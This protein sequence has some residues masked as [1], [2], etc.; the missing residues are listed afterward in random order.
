M[1][2]S[3]L[4]QPAPPQTSVGRPFGRPPWVISSKPP[5]PVG[6]LGRGW[7]APTPGAAAEMWLSIRKGCR[8][9]SKVLVDDGR[10]HG[11]VPGDGG[12]PRAGGGP[13]VRHALA[14]DR[15]DE[16][17]Q[18]AVLPG[19]LEP[20]FGE[21][22]GVEP[23]GDGLAHRLARPRWSHTSECNHRSTHATCKYKARQGGP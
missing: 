4:P 18:G 12:I 9:P 20:R 6:A 15:L 14:H 19:R 10:R 21:E 2:K 16:V 5:I 22:L 8:C 17:G 13:R 23:H 1:A 3:V 11:R 7:A